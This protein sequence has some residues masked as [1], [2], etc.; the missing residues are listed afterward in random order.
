MSTEKSSHNLKVE[1][2]YLVRM[3]RT[4]SP[5]DSRS[6]P[7]RKLLQGDRREVRL[8]T[9]LQ[10][11]EQEVWISKIRYQVKECSILCMGRCKPLGSLT[12]FLSYAT[13]LSR[14]VLFHCSP[15]FLH[16]PRSSAISVG[17]GGISWVAVMRAL[18]HIWRPEIADDWHFLFLDM[19]GDIFISDKLPIKIA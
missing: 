2:F 10:Q 11:R 4:P 1:L 16:S 5:G 6:V 12:S 9:S 13:Q 17:A 7:L 3:F 15:W 19:A 8:C 18:I 14:P